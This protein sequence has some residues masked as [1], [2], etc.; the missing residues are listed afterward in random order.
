M[1]GFSEK[2]D[3]ISKIKEYLE[4]VK[5][6]NNFEKIESCLKGNTQPLKGGKKYKNG[7]K[8]T[9][10]KNK[11]IKKIKGGF[12]M[13]YIIFNIVRV[14]HRLLNNDY[15][16]NFVIEQDLDE[17]ALENDINV[18]NSMMNNTTNFDVYM[19]TACLIVFGIMMVQ[20][21]R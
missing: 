14:M 10:K 7:K 5:F 18:I 20:A 9:M 17:S 6:E 15:N 8:Y 11:K 13:N 12:S 4:E 1:T 19:A 2:K 16:E 21:M 3:I